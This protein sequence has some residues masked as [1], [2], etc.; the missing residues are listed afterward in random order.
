MYCQDATIDGL[1]MAGL[2][3]QDCCGIIIDSCKQVRI[4]NCS[5]ASGA[6]CIG[7]KS[8]YNEDGR[9][10]GLPSED[11]VVTN[12]NLTHSYAAGIAIGSETAGGIKNVAISNC[13]ITNCKNG[14]HIRSTRGR[15]GVVERVRV[16]NVVMD[17]LDGSAIVMVQF[18]DSIFQGVANP[19]EPRRA[20][21]RRDRQLDPAAGGPGH[22][23][24]SGTST[25]AA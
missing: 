5:L 6:D 21:H 23:R 10:V 11:I 22:A 8:G 15:G 9:R 20:A 4:A 3:A 1:N 13:V 14:V 12:C 16:S 24:P 17:R 25:S 18:F 7:I 19:N 2:Q